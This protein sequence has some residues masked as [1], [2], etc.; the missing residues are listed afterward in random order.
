M[1]G[2]QNA[3]R[4]GSSNYAEWKGM[5]RDRPWLLPSNRKL[6][7]LQGI[8]LRNLTLSQPQTRLR[9]KTIDDESLPNAFKS[10]AKLLA[11]RETHKLEH[12]RSSNDLK[13]PP[14]KDVSSKPKLVGGLDGSAEARPSMGRLRRRSTLNWTGAS[15]AVRQKKLEDVTGGR[16][17]D[18]W[19][20]LHCEGVE[21]P[22][23]VSET[24]EKA[25]NPNFR[26][27]DL[28]A[29][30]P[31]ASRLD[32]VTV[33]FWAKSESMKDYRLLIELDLHLRSLQFIGKSVEN[34]HHPLPSNCILFQLSDGVYTSFT[35]LPPEEPPVPQYFKPSRVIA[36]EVQPTS[37]FDAL[38][39]LS[40]L[41][42]CIQDAL[43]TREK[44]A[45][46]ITSILQ[47]NQ[48]SLITINE[49]SQ[50]RES[51]AAVKRAVTAE[52]KQLKAATTRRHDLQTSLQARREAMLEGCKAQQK[53]QEHLSGA[54]SKLRGCGT[55]V[56]KNTEAIRGQIRRICEDLSQIYP[57]DPI[58]HK[59][60]S[61]TIHGLSLPNSNYDSSSAEED[62]ISA[63]L[64]FVAHLVYLLSFYLSVPLP[65]PIQPYASTSFI[66]DPISILPPGQRTF[67]L[68][69]KGSVAYRFDYGVFL[70][71]KDIELLI[72]R[73]GLKM[74]DV[75]HT[76]PNVKYLLYVLTAGS[77]DLPVRKAGGVRGLL[78]EEGGGG[79]PCLSRRESEDSVDRAVDLRMIVENGGRVDGRGKGKE[80]E[81]LIAVENAKSSYGSLKGVNSSLRSS[82]V[83]KV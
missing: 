73:Q 4:N 65:Y 29:S 5:R 50:S 47:G 56:E 66:K 35:D 69:R 48:Q 70:L 67:P 40:N 49:A 28:N 51:L 46:Q 57:I 23:Y 59:L 19:F 71:N 54:Q 32:E 21:E 43:A 30:G 55:L 37:S 68:H 79:T 25:M 2:E 76:L 82:A 63:A 33:K 72:G 61:F 45:S 41:D 15:P 12:S 62:T 64:G 14:P 27:F 58:P 81:K 80:K 60:V 16:M 42:D 38:M 17:A 26:F 7:H 75:R 8:C 39:R 20:S 36:H 22:I 1:S 74:L 34:F 13:S 3:G 52:R 11:Q 78:R 53:A 77:N 31:L 24:V 9:G 44:L 18:T 10:P 6:R 83:S